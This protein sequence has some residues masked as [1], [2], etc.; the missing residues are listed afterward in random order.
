M[1]HDTRLQYICMPRPA[2]T[3]WMWWG[4]CPSTPIQATLADPHWAGTL[5]PVCSGGVCIKPMCMHTLSSPLWLI[6]NDLVNPPSGCR[7]IEALNLHTPSS[8][9]YLFWEL[10]AWVSPP[11]GPARSRWQNQGRWPTEQEEGKAFKERWAASNVSLRICCR[12]RKKK[13]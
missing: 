10:H 13:H 9:P 2:C 4:H 12:K 7:S 5:H 8:P 6:T 11:Q 1:S 3:G